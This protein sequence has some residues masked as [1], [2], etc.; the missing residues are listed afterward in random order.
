MAIP[1]PPLANQVTR[2]RIAGSTNEG[3]I[4]LRLYV[5]GW[6]KEKNDH[7]RQTLIDET[8]IAEKGGA[9]KDTRFVRT[10]EFKETKIDTECGTLVMWLRSTRKTS[11]SLIAVEFAY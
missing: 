7:H 6:D 11:I 10:F 4:V 3:E 1:I 5:G 8:I 9:S 2:F